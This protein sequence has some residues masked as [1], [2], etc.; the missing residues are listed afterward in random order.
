MDRLDIAT[1]KVI[2]RHSMI[3]IGAYADE[4]NSHINI[5]N[6]YLHNRPIK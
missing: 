1:Y 6:D 5:T 4:Y 3:V 2:G